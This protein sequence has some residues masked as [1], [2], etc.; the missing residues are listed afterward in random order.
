MKIK[1]DGTVLGVDLSSPMIELDRGNLAYLQSDNAKTRLNCG[2]LFV[3]CSQV[4]NGGSDGSGSD[5][6]A[7][8]AAAAAAASNA[9]T[10]TVSPVR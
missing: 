7:A 1:D 2:Q 8:A 5:G 4:C 9:V 3:P 6:G 10:V